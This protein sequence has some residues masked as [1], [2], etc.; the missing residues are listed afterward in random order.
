VPVHVATHYHGWSMDRMGEFGCRSVFFVLQSIYSLSDQVQASPELQ[1][2]LSHVTFDIFK[3][4]DHG[5]HSTLPERLPVVLSLLGHDSRSGMTGTPCIPSPLAF[6][7][8]ISHTH[9][10]LHS[11]TRGPCSCVYIRVSRLSW[12]WRAHQ[13]L[14]PLLNIS[15]EWPS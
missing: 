8:H 12:C 5:F 3:S 9:A 14:T 15:T 13:M 6:A 11:C 1:H 7:C 4:V 10:R 2:G